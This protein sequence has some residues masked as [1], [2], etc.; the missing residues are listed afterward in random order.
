MMSKKIEGT[1]PEDSSTDSST[2]CIS[3][4]AVLEINE[5]HHGQ[6]PNEVNHQIWKEIE[7]LSSVKPKERTGEWQQ[8]RDGT[9]FCSECGSRFKE[10]PTVMGK[11]M[12]LFCPLCG[13][14]MKKGEENE[15]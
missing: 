12:F 2:D 4:K 9:Y 15:C 14:R 13:V 11:P 5:S 10:Q 7:E 6:M 1:F 8:D 3:R